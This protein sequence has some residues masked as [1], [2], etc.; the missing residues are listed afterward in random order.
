MPLHLPTLADL[1]RDPALNVLE[2]LRVAHDAVLET[3]ATQ[4]EAAA[5]T[6]ITFVQQGQALGVWLDA[7]ADRRA[8]QSLLDYWSTRFYRETGADVDATLASFDPNVAPELKDEACPYLGLE[9]FDE[10]QAALFFG[11]RR[12]IEEMI[13]RLQTCSLLAVVGTSGSGKS[14]VV[15]AGLLPHLRQADAERGAGDWQYLPPIVPGS[16]PLEALRRWPDPLPARTVL[17]IDQFEELFTLCPDETTRATFTQRVLAWAQAGQR[18]I[19][20]LRADFEA[21]VNKLPAAFAELFNANIVRVTPMSAADLREAIT[22]P[23]ECVGL[24][25]QPE[26]VDALVND[27]SGEAAA[28]PLLQFTLWALWGKRQRNRV[29]LAAYDEIGRARDALSNAAD[30]FYANLI[31]EKKEAA[32]RLLLRLVKINDNLEVTSQRLRRADLLS[33]R[34]GAEQRRAETLDQLIAARLVRQ[35]GAG[36]DAQVEVA[37]EALVRSWRTLLDWLEEEREVVRQRNRLREQSQRWRNAGRETSFLWSG[38]ELRQAEAIADPTPEEAEYIE[39]CRAVV[40]QAAREKE[41]ARQREFELQQQHE[42]ERNARRITQVVSVLGTIAFIAGIIAVYFALQSNQQKTVA[43]NAST[44]AVAQKLNAEAASTQAVV[45]ANKANTQQAKADNAQATAVVAFAEAVSQ[46]ATSEAA[47]TL[48]VNAQ[49]N[50]QSALSRQLVAQAKSI[51]KEKPEVAL[52]LGIEAYKIF[53]TT[54]ASTMLSATTQALLTRTLEAYGNPLP[55]EHNSISR[56]A[57]SP[58]G[59]TLASILPNGSVSFWEIATQNRIG[60]RLETRLDDPGSVDFSRDGNQI[61][62]CGGQL[63]ALGEMRT[64]IQ[65]WDLSTRN[66][67]SPIDLSLGPC[68][69]ARFGTERNK[70][71]IARDSLVGLIWDISQSK[72]LVQLLDGH[73]DSISTLAWSPIDATLATGGLDGLVRIWDTKT[74]ELTRTPD[75][76]TFG[77][78]INFLDWSPD[79]K[80]LAIANNNGT[81]K[82]LQIDPRETITTLSA[83]FGRVFQVG[84]SSN[85][86]WLASVD[87]GP[88]LVIWDVESGQKLT[89]HNFDNVTPYSLAFSPVEN[90]IVAGDNLGQIYLFRLREPPQSSD[91]VELACELASHNFTQEEWAQYFPGEDYR[92]TCPKSTAGSELLRH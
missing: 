70:I 82:I 62:V 56:L 40:E 74:G 32:R 76:K 63:N 91:I 84:F 15:R 52:L 38:L 68:N 3:Y 72:I 64:R 11:R 77:S 90:L 41:A 29:L 51:V 73:R 1:Q 18:I 22:L 65:I 47:S 85:G 31:P 87:A 44:Q 81:I 89:E 88:R 36:D 46:R 49:R 13:E 45:Q 28:L 67:L 34:A 7:R 27:V 2:A 66:A 58:D 14:S 59:H 60:G 75:I 12:L 20:T 42:R 57:F 53:S 26:L 83:G 80:K 5:Q 78:P 21:Q 50:A 86:R 39:A 6:V 9:A 10:P 54:E 55:S 8:A 35:T 48:A 23:A 24:R 92:L 16:E 43:E 37:H 71:A 25:L 30:A 69:A 19:I 33:Q 79:G 61:M 17:V 4:P